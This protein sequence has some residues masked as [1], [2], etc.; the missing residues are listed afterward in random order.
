M[1]SGLLPTLARDLRLCLFC[2]TFYFI[3]VRVEAELSNLLRGRLS[4]FYVNFGMENGFLPAK[5]L[6][7]A[8][9]AYVRDGLSEDENGDENLFENEDFAKGYGQCKHG[10]PEENA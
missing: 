10:I 7:R 2:C 6:E 1:C 8:N 3:F 5:K 4:F 9:E